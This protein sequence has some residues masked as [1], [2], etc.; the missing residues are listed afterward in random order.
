MSLP[1]HFFNKLLLRKHCYMIIISLFAAFH[2]VHGQN[3]HYLF[4]I[5]AVDSVKPNGSHRT[6]ASAF[7]DSIFDHFEVTAYQ[8]TFPGA[9]NPML[10]A[11]CDLHAIGDIFENRSIFL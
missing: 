10:A 7:I 5:P 1:M 8:Y 2:N 6:I 4:V 11:T 3:K 9:S